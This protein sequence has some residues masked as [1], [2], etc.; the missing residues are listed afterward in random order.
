MRELVDAL[1]VEGKNELISGFHNATDLLT[2]SVEEKEILARRLSAIN[3]VARI[4]VHPYFIQDSYPK[5]SHVNFPNY[6]IVGDLVEKLVAMP[7]GKTPPVFIFQEKKSIDLLLKHLKGKIKQNIYIVE[8]ETS[9]IRLSNTDWSYS[10]LKDLFASLGVKKIII[11]GQTLGIFPET[12]IDKGNLVFPDSFKL[13]SYSPWINGCVGD[14]INNLQ[15]GV[16]GIQIS[17]FNLPSSLK[18][19]RE[20]FSD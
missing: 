1:D 11:G 5:Q 13:D 7:E 20:I 10:K 2:L 8:T 18:D 17:N 14:V 9:D 3:G 4:F 6:Q 16:F 19:I 15:G 12:L